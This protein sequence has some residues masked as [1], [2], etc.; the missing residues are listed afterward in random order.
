MKMFNDVEQNAIRAVANGG[1]VDA[2]L[3]FVAQF[4]PERGKM[5]ALTTAGYSFAKPEIGV[6]VMASGFAA[7]RLQGLLRRQAAQ[8]T[9]SGLL[10]NN[11]PPIRPSM[12]PS[13][14]MG[15]LLTDPY[16]AP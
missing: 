9:I 3:S 6:P 15:S 2:L 1:S 14:V 13:G 4:N 12:T 11:L 7:D 16:I 8:N 5:A 10:S